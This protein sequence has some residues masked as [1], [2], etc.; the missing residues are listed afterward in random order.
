MLILIAMIGMIGCLKND[1]VLEPIDTEGHLQAN[2]RNGDTVS[3]LMQLFADISNQ[4]GL[5][6]AGM[7]MATRFSPDWNS[8]FYL[9]DSVI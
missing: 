6:P 5:D 9:N 2:L 8:M 4:A 1:P 7:D 3:V